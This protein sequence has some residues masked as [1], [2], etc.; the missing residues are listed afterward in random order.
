MDKEKLGIALIVNG[1][2]YILKLSSDELAKVRTGIFLITGVLMI[3]ILMFDLV[4][5]IANN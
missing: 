1:M 3:L 5:K 2:R 4:E